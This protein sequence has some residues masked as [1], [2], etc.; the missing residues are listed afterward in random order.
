MTRIHH[1]HIPAI[2]TLLGA[3]LHALFTATLAQASDREWQLER[4]ENDIRVYT[5]DVAN[6]PYIAVKATTVIRAPVE[7][8]QQHLGGGERCMEWRDMC[9]S[10]RVV[11]TVSEHERYVHMVLDLP[12]PI[13]DRDMVIHTVTTIDP[14]TRTATVSLD[15]ASDK[16]PATDLIRAETSG[17]FQLRVL[18]PEETEFTYMMQTDLR[19]DLPAGTVNGRMAASAYNDLRRLRKLAER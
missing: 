14:T 18:G 9:K 12:W 6:S 16:I 8:L 10:A 2:L 17:S 4:E 19:G 13:S 1:V 3:I 11:E 5:R 15:S 7:E